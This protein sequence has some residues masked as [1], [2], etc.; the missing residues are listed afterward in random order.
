M[1]EDT[2]AYLFIWYVAYA[3][4]YAVICSKGK[5]RAKFG[6]LIAVIPSLISTYISL[7][8]PSAAPIPF[9]MAIP[10]GLVL[11][12]FVIGWYAS[13]VALHRQW[14]KH[15]PRLGMIGGAGA[16]PTIMV[17]VPVFGPFIAIPW[18]IILAHNS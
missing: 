12:I 11:M 9:S 17:T 6:F 2:F 10:P 15:Y 18:A 1:P 3:L 4:P 14:V 13:W 16:L 5:G 7:T 8:R